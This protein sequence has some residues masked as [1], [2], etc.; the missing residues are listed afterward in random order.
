MGI[1]GVSNEKISYVTQPSPSQPP[2]LVYDNARLKLIFSGDFLKQD[3]V[4]H[5]PAPIVNI[6]VV[7][8]LI[9]GIN[10]SGF[11]LENCLFGEINLTKMLILINTNI[12][13]MVLDLIQKDLFYI[14]VIDLVKMLLFLELI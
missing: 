12:L 7:Y 8:R 5:N 14:Q 1:K 9:P 13:D 2:S 4:T 11:T 10:N 3:K 6:Y